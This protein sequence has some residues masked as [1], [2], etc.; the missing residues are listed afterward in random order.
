LPARVEEYLRSERARHG[1]ALRGDPQIFAPLLGTR[2]GERLLVK[3]VPGG[4]E[5][6]ALVLHHR[7]SETPS[8]ERLQAFAFSRREAEVFQRVMEGATNA[9][10]A[11]D[12]YISPGTVKKHLENVYRKLGARNRATAVATVVDLWSMTT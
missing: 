8:I 5:L 11:R 9:T 7:R 6:D 3:F 10:I 4:S 2:G 12:L 1:D